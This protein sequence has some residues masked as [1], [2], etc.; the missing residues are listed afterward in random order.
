M[1]DT[2]PVGAASLM[3]IAAMLG[4]AMTSGCA[5]KASGRQTDSMQKSGTLSV[6]AA[7]LR[8]RVNDT[9]TSDRGRIE[10]AADVMYRGHAESCRPS[11]RAR[12]Q[13]GRDSAV[14]SAA[15][16]V[17]PFAGA[18]DVWVLAFQMTEYL[19][20]GAGREAFG[21]EQPLARKGALDVLA[22]T[23]AVVRSLTRPA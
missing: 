18:I 11:S 1:T 22:D 15:Y 9:G 21:A 10:E 12:V 2:R 20:D 23:D 8:A 6:S 13:D 19:E 4:L 7:Q 16:R 17:D 3:A 5:A 14:Y